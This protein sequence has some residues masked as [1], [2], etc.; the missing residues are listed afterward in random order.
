MLRSRILGSIAVA[1]LTAAIAASTASASVPSS[2]AEKAATAE[3]NRKISME[4]AAAEARERAQ[5]EAYEAQKRAYE[6]QRQQY[7]QQVKNAEFN[8]APSPAP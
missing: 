5:L 8:R 4:N 6:Q 2:P 7:E 3:L 1:A